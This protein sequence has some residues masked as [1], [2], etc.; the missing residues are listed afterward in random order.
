V[1]FVFQVAAV[2]SFHGPEAV[3]VE[4]VDA[5]SH[6]ADPSEWQLCVPRIAAWV[7]DR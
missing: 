1:A 5:A 7:A 4:A 3:E 2:Q 6:F